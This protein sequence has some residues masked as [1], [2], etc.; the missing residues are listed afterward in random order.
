MRF[1]ELVKLAAFV[2][3]FA[4]ACMLITLKSISAWA[5]DPG[6]MCAAYSESVGDG[7]NICHGML[8]TDFTN[9]WDMGVFDCPTYDEK[10]GELIGYE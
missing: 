1:R 4:I 5:D 2:L 7:R 8:C 3:L 10:G 9:T 6:I